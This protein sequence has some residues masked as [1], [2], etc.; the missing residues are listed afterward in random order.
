[1]APDLHHGAQQD[2]A[3]LRGPQPG[4]GPWQGRA[5][6]AAARCGS[7]RDSSHMLSHQPRSV[8]PRNSTWGAGTSALSP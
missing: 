1:M 6:R 5:C 3:D 4:A 2:S 8:M 7:V